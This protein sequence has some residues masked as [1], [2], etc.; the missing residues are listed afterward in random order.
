MNKIILTV[1]S[2]T[3][4]IKLKRLLHRA[5]LWA[6]TIKLDGNDGVTGCLHAVEISGEDLY[7]AVVI[8]KENQIE[9]RVYQK[10]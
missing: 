1:R 8:L 4:A 10:K 3:Y 2:P 7:S 6:R 5:G 9:Y